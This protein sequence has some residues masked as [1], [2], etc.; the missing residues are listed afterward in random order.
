MPF[1]IGRLALR[2]FTSAKRA[3]TDFLSN[4]SK[5]LLS[6]SN[7]A[8][9]SG[10]NTLIFGALAVTGVSDQTTLECSVQ[11]NCVFIGGSANS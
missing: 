2:T 8:K 9:P 5:R 1:L 10:N 6:T 11:N 3:A 4:Q 7:A